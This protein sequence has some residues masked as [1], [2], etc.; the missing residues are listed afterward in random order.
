[1]DPR[2]AVGA[3]V[4]TPT[5]AVQIV[6]VHPGEGAGQLV[7]TVG[8]FV[9]PLPTVVARLVVVKLAQ[10]TQQTVSPGPV[11]DASQ[12]AGGPGQPGGP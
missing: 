1:M 3:P 8:D 9:L 4:V 12:G 6:E 7:L 2:A 10:H 5:P 11:T